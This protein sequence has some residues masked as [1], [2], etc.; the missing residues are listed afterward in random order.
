M[1]N[2][3]E[4]T[5]NNG[6]SQE[7]SV[8]PHLELKQDVLP[9]V[10]DS[11]RRA[12]MSVSDH[13]RADYEILHQPGN[14]GLPSWQESGT[15]P[16]TPLP[17]SCLVFTPVVI[18]TFWWLRRG[19]WRGGWGKRIWRGKSSGS[20]HILPTGWSHWILLSH[21]A[22]ISPPSSSNIFQKA[23]RGNEARQVD[24]KNC[25]DNLIFNYSVINKI[26]TPVKNKQQHTYRIQ[27]HDNLEELLQSLETKKHTKMTTCVQLLQSDK[28]FDLK[29][30]VFI[31]RIVSVFLNSSP[32]DEMYS[33]LILLAAFREIEQIKTQKKSWIITTALHE[34]TPGRLNKSHNKI[35]IK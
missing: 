6:A 35:K 22:H 16:P 34:M 32:R 24:R 7:W 21:W 9:F 23:G 2:C 14:T 5:L 29:V 12:T 25:F 19:R 27:E 15:R 8:W 30:N 1:S 28:S 17:L 10:L 3:P 4:Y 20:L 11:R 18:T 33:T 26:K 31:N 13:Q